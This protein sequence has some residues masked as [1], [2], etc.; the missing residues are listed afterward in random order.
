MEERYSG[1][2]VESGKNRSQNKLPNQADCGKRNDMRHVIK[3]SAHLACK[4]IFPKLQCHKKGQDID[5]NHVI[6]RVTHGKKKAF[7]EKLVMKNLDKVL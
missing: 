1:N 7:P 4:S 6:N 2:I 5:Q 3:G